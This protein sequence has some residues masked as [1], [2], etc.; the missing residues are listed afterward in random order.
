MRV[1][2]V[3][4]EVAPFAKTGGLADVS[5]ALPAALARAGID[6]R[7]CM[8]RYGSI[9]IPAPSS[10]V[11]ESGGEIVETSLGDV[12]VWMVDHPGY[13]D[14]PGL[15]GEGG[16]DYEDNLERFAFFCRAALAWCR[17]SG[18]IP[19]VVHCNDWQTALIPVYLKIAHCGDPDLRDVASLLTVHN[20]A[21]QG[22]FPAERF[23]ATGLPPELFSS[24]ALEF[25]GKVNLLKGGLVFADLLSTVSPTY[26]REIQTPEFG[27]G[28]DGVLRERAHDLYGILNGADY[29]VWDP[30]VDELIPARYSAADLSGKAVCKAELQREFGLDPAPEA[31]LLGVVSRLTDQKGLD[32]IAACLDRIVAAGAQFVLLGTGDPKYQDLFRNAAR[33]HPGSV[34]V[35][36]GFDERLAHWIE[37]GADIFLMPSRYEP[38]GLNQLYSLRYGT[39]PVVR[40]TGGLA[41]SITD[42]TPDAIERGEATGF[43]FVD[44]TA[45]ALWTAIERAL[46][47]H[48]DPEIW[49]RL[50]Q[51]GMAADFS[52]DRA[53]AGYVELYR[54]A[55][56]R[57]RA[58]RDFGDRGYGG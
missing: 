50:V 55:V 44:Y 7:I 36:I 47:A 9:P 29:T 25:W 8:P 32:L 52:W 20:L 57:R 37:A 53:A 48:R 2:F 24:A 17:Q 16:R 21:Y 27:C 38:S 42:A 46:A 23:S 58:G 6:A 51:A 13:F 19:D 4:S 1:L 3:S 54:K 28:L 39:V 41:D 10:L 34:G 15:Y 56:E 11:R 26:A 43:V 14:R 22:V 31:P 18:W 30:W 33:S 12:T 5:A 35:R 49:S 40:R 45:D